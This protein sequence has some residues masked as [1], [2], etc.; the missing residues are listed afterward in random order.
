MLEGGSDYEE[1]GG[2]LDNAPSTVIA[3]PKRDSLYRTTIE[4]PIVVQL[5]G[6]QTVCFEAGQN[7][8][9]QGQAYWSRVKYQLKELLTWSREIR[10]G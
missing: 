7:L 8:E 1:E 6:G 3:V 9:Q 10:V 5:K 2:V 4:M